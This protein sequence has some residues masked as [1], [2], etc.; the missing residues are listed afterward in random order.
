MH[1]H[2]RDCALTCL[3]PLISGAADNPLLAGAY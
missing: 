2:T 3:K 1:A